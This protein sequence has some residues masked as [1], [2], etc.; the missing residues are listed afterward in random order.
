M[1]EDIKNI[2]KTLKTTLSK[3]EVLKNQ[4]IS[5]LSEEERAEIA[6]ITKEISNATRAI[7]KGNSEVLNELLKKYAGSNS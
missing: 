4:A 1:H 3:V 7:K 5:N 2:M 6:P